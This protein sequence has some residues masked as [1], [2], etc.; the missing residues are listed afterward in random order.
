MEKHVWT[1]YDQFKGK[2]KQI[3][4]EEADAEDLKWLDDLQNKMKN[5]E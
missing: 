4:S 1:V 3:E 5:K 2:G